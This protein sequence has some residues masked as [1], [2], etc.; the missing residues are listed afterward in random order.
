VNHRFKNRFK[1]IAYLFVLSQTV[2]KNIC[3]LIHLISFVILCHSAPQGDIEYT[4]ECVCT[5]N[6]EKVCKVVGGVAGRRGCVGQLTLYQGERCLGQISFVEPEDGE[7]RPIAKDRNR[8]NLRIDSVQ[9]TGDCC[10]EIED[11][12]G[13]YKIVDP[14]NPIDTTN[15]DIATVYVYKGTFINDVP[16]FMAISDLPTYPLLLYNVPF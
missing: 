9:A 15:F 4:E 3:I 5:A 6:G 12:D 10:W 8:N 2:M 14:G 16:C 13:D 1:K 11:N 7:S